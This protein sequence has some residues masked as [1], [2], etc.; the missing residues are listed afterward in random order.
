MNGQEMI[1]VF[2]SRIMAGK[3]NERK[4]WIYS[5]AG[6][7]CV[8]FVTALSQ[9]CLSIAEWQKQLGL[10]ENIDVFEGVCDYRLLKRS[11][12]V[13]LLNKTDLFREY[14]KITPL[15]FCFG[16]EYKGKNYNDR[17]SDTDGM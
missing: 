3:E 13:L 6:Q 12:I 10:L 11:M 9:Y 5:L 7:N 8:I 15:T 1:N 16:D 17:L 2:L 14:W 4:K